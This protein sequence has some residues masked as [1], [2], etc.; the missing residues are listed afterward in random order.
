MPKRASLD[1][2]D[3]LIVCG[4]ATEICVNWLVLSGL[5]NGYSVYVVTSLSFPESM[6]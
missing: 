2:P 4:V 3:D 6:Y 5:A 1:P